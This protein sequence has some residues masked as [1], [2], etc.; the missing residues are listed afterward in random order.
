VDS[1]KAASQGGVEGTVR[2]VRRRIRLLWIGLGTYFLII[3]NAV[4]IAHRVP[5]QLFVLG[6][7]LNVA[8]VT[9]IVILLRRAYRELNK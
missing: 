3:L 9:G 5:Y 1:E 7:L 4:R 8:I 2:K 6:A